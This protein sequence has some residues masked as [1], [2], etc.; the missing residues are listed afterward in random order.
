LVAIVDDH[1]V[2]LQGLEALIGREPDMTVV[3]SARDG[4]EAVRRILATRPDVVVMDVRMPGCD[5]I[6]ATE[7]ILTANPATKII[8]LS[9]EEGPPVVEGIRAGALSFLSKS[10]IGDHLVDGIREAAKGQPVVS[11]GQLGILLQAIREPE[12]ALPLS[13]REREILKLVA[14]GR[15]NEQ[16]A[17]AIGT[18][19]STVKNQ[20]ASLF[21]KLGADDRASAVATGMRRGWLA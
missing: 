5:G 21:E 8:L 6:A 2:V 16:I 20:L 10:S 13:A 15:T 11:A 7:R 18:S 14:D 1:P 12:P 19:L 4:E 3:A 17:R 9:G